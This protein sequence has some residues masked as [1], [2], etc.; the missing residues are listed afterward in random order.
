MTVA[1]RKREE[2]RGGRQKASPA[3]PRAESAESAESARSKQEEGNESVCTHAAFS[4]LAIH[5]VPFV[6]FSRVS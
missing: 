2:E 4:A 6:D 5:R 3:R 1:W